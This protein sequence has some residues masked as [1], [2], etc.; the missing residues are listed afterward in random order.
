M[1]KRPHALYRDRFIVVIAVLAIAVSPSCK[2]DN[3]SIL[4]EQKEQAGEARI[5]VELHRLEKELSTAKEPG[6]K[7]SLLEKIAGIHFRKGDVASAM[8][9]ARSGLKINDNNSALH[10][11]MGKSYLAA[12]RY[13]D[14]ETELRKALDMDPAL[15]QSHFELGNCLY[16]KGD[17]DGAARE[18]GSC[19]AGDAAHGEAFNNLGIM[20]VRL[21]KFR[22]AETM[23]KNAIAA[24]NPYLRAR[25]NLA[26]LYE[27]NLK[28][29]AKALEQY[30]LYR[31]TLSDEYERRVISLWMSDLGGR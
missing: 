4:L 3:A 12:C 14:A 30:R 19:L 17:V 8:D 7:C 5:N 10:F 18:Y 25:K 1:V 22:E 15:N 23:F 6:E 31:E 21:G 24:N 20:Y 13:R 27:K 9:A 26:I 29:R 16:L 11:V 28:N 2:K